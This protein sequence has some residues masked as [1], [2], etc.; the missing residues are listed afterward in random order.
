MFLSPVFY[1]ASQIPERF[2]TLFYLNPLTFPIEDARGALI[3][4]RVPEPGHLV[5][6]LLAGI[7]IAQLGFWWFQKT[8]RGF[9]DVI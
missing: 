3:F 5:I 6:E 1:P 4:G 9:A 8:R 7:V 2:K